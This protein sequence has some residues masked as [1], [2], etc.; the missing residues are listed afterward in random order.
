MKNICQVNNNELT[1]KIWLVLAGLL[2]RI[3]SLIGL[4]QQ[5]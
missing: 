3:L 4:F 5:K 2:R 1:R